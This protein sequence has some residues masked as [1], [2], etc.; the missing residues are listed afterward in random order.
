M[1]EF[2]LINFSKPLSRYFK[3]E[4]K[5]PVSTYKELRLVLTNLR[6]PVTPPVKRFGH[7]YNF[8]PST[9]NSFTLVFTQ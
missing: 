6:L 8:I 1:I 7:F 4:I 3:S 2:L 9:S 5:I